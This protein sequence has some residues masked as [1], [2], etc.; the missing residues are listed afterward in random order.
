MASKKELFALVLSGASTIGKEFELSDKV[1]EAFSNMITLILEP[2]KGGGKV[3]LAEVTRVDEDGNLVEIQCS[4]SGVWLPANAINFYEDKSGTGT[5]IGTDGVA[6]K[7]ESI[8]GLRVFRE[9]KRAVKASKEAILADLASG[10]VEDIAALQTELMALNN[11]KPDFSVI[12]ALTG[13]EQATDE[14]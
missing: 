12:V 9:H 14:V 8:E 5:L 2:K 3:D 10:E 13:E 1:N 7:R 6:L 4:K 11:S